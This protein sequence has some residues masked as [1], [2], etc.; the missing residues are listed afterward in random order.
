MLKDL[1]W[2][3]IWIQWNDLKML[4]FWDLRRYSWEQLDWYYV[5]I[6]DMWVG[7]SFMIMGSLDSMFFF[8]VTLFLRFYLCF[9]F[10]SY[11]WIYIYIYILCPTIFDIGKSCIHISFWIILTLS[12]TYVFFFF[13]MPFYLITS[14][15][16]WLS[17]Y[18]AFFCFCLT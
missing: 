5:H 12:L 3:L 8:G 2:D 16:F 15:L 1:I 10:F 6:H 18:L 11:I 7:K 4:E 14:M 17:L 13:I 9:F